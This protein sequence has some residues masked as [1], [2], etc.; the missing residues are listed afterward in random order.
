MELVDSVNELPSCNIHTNFTVIQL[1][2]PLLK[3]VLDTFASEKHFLNVKVLHLQANNLT[4]RTNEYNNAMFF[5]FPEPLF[6]TYGQK[7]LGR[8]QYGSP[9][10]YMY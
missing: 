7:K 4:L 10:L 8:T 9:R 6:A 3:A 1:V 2:F 5:N